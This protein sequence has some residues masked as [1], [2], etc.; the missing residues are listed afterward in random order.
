MG[1]KNHLFEGGSLKKYWSDRPP[2]GAKW[3]WW[4]GE[5]VLGSIE[6]CKGAVGGLR[7]WWRE[8]EGEKERGKE[9][10]EEAG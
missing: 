9:K 1:V 8:K 7:G 5:E 3:K 4:V 10:E 2:E 6:W